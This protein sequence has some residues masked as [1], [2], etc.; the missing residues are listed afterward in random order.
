MTSEAAVKSYVK[1][2]S[3]F[4]Q[5]LCALSCFACRIR[6]SRWVSHVLIKNTPK[7]MD[8]NIMAESIKQAQRG[9]PP[10]SGMTL[11]PHLL[12]SHHSPLFYLLCRP[13]LLT[14][15]CWPFLDQRKS[16]RRLPKRV[17][18]YA[19]TA[20]YPPKNLHLKIKVIRIRPL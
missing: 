3:G 5:R 14:R 7:A 1:G 20:L 10:R 4:L 18:C 15:G 16:I 6:A 11:Y 8:P 13:G 12:A 17:R 9:A 2:E 19:L